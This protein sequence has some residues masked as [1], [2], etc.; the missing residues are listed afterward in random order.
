MIQTGNKNSN[1]IKKQHNN[2]EKKITISKLKKIKFALLTLTFL[3]IFVFVILELV[4]Y[5]LKYD[6]TYSKMERFTVEKAK[7]WADDSNLGPRYVAN[8]VDK[9]DSIEFKKAGVSWY[10]DRL[11]IVNNEGYHDRDNFNEL[12]ADT[13][14]L[15]VLFIGDSF[16]WGA[17]ADVDSS[18]VDVFKK[19]IKSAMPGVVWN[20]GIPA[21][22]TNYALFVTKKYLPLQKSN[23][24]ILGF[25]NDNDFDDNLVPFDRL[26][27]TTKASCFNLYKFD[28]ELNTIPVSVKEAYKKATGSA[29]LEELNFVQ[30]IL[31]RSRLI[32]FIRE[33]KER[34]SN[35]I[36]GF[37]KKKTKLEY[38]VTKDYLK[39]LNDYVKTNNAELIV[40]IIPTRDD[41]KKPGD[42]YLKAKKIFEGLSI[43]Y[44]EVIGLLS[45]Q[46]Y[47]Q[48]I[49]DW[50]NSGH[51]ITG[52]ALS[53]YLLQQVKQ[54]KSL[55]ARPLEGKK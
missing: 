51:R 46:N 25:C 13:S 36:N 44:F 31:I 17:S 41:V 6:S 19:D 47:I 2:M 30:K 3:L 34:L 8:Q 12:P 53:T 28:D 38:S 9:T 43:K 22:G 10:Y 40:L 15:R 14:L 24:V 48:S 42:Y 54:K 16:T 37:N 21:T 33:V 4:L 7:W 1:W 11:R 45:Q 39:Q 29:P 35:R 49:G 55:I 5:F 18:Y 27:F 23:Y 52:H 32:A 26:V 20:T 50:N